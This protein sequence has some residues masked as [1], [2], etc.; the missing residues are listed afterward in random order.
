[1]TR[2]SSV[3]T[4][5]GGDAPPTALSRLVDVVLDPLAAF[6]GV[7]VR[8]T[9]GVAFLALVALRFGSVLAFYRPDTTPAKL[10]AG[11]LFQIATLLPL[12]T[13]TT[14]VLWLV[15][16]TCRV[17]VS[18]ASAW[19]VATHVTFA[20]T[21]L[22]VA[23]ASIAGALLPESSDVH[24]RNPPFTNLG[25]VVDQLEAPVAHAM[26]AE[27]DVRS[28]YAVTLMWLGV[29]EASRAGGTKTACVVILCF[30]VAVVAAIIS[31]MLR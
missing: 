19:C 7:D 21:L 3:S 1:M 23:I 18:W 2:S 8:P 20:Y 17:R 4:L 28:A 10:A 5:T 15:A 13:L 26:L 16:L 24:L 12:V 27:V 29:R 9:W 14:L 31:A 25:F 30:G 11:M 22:T 6:R